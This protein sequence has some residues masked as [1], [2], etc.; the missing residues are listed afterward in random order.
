M[1]KFCECVDNVNCVAENWLFDEKVCI[2]T[3]G[4]LITGLVVIPE[5]KSLDFGI[6]VAYDNV[7]HEV[8][9]KNVPIKY[10]PM[11]GREL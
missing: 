3:L 8:F 6:Q 5:T 11:C 7:S 4:D 1:C 9:A 2:G 10:C